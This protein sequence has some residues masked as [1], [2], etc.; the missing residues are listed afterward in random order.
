M[1]NIFGSEAIKQNISLHVN[2][3]EEQVYIMADRIQIQQ[4]LL[5]FF[6]NATQAMQKIKATDKIIVISETV[7]EDFVNVSVRDYGEGISDALKERLFQPFV[8]SKKEGT[9][10]GLAISRSIIDDHHGKIRAENMPGGGAQFSFSMK[11]YEDE[12]GEL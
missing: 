5:N 12:P 7:E 6:T 10:I 8:T 9:G 3:F 2:L 4:V 11:I 1:V